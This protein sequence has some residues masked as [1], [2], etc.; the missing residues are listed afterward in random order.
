VEH[1]KETD[2]LLSIGD[3]RVSLLLHLLAQVASP[4]FFK[5]G[6]PLL[7][8]EWSEMNEVRQ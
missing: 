7:A 4:Q 6:V 8:I 2:V 1:R 3:I 5:C